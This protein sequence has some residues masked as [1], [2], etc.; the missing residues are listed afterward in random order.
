MSIK[1]KAVRKYLEM[2]YRLKDTS[3]WT[4][5]TS[6]IRYFVGCILLPKKI[7]KQAHHWSDIEL[8]QTVV[9]VNVTLVLVPKSCDKSN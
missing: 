5:Q 8:L 7:N 9:K 3:E 2:L 6:S 4:H 1:S